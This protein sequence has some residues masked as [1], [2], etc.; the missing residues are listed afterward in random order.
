MPLLHATT[1]TKSWGPLPVLRGL[2]LIV[3]P[4]QIAVIMGENGAG[5]STLL[6]CLAGDA[7]LD[8]GSVTVKGIDLR[9]EPDRARR[10]LLHLA[11]HPPLAQDLSPNEHATAMA[12]FRDRDK[13]ATLAEFQRLATVLRCDAWL[14]R[15]VRALSGGTAHK[16]A[17][18]L[19]FAAGADLLLLDEPHAGLDVRS[20]LALRALILEARAAG[21][22]LILASHLAEATLAVADRALVLHKGRFTLDLDRAAL[23]EFHG[24][25]RAFEQAVLAGMDAEPA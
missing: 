12:G 4:S 7:S 5:K 10:H 6:A 15:P 16:V 24:D 1:L 23:A 25:A 2:D 17:L 9:A 11:Q 18:A 20:A 19:A 22:S 3:E 21:R 14:H 13:Q 8:A